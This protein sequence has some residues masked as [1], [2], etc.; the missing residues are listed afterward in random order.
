MLFDYYSLYACLFSKEKQGV[1][2]GGRGD[3]KNLR[4]NE[5]EEAVLRM[6]F[7]Q[8]KSISIKGKKLKKKRFIFQ[9]LDKSSGSV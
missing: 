1:D 2:S 3:G 7:V 5:G 6:Y 9:D 8:T 4:G